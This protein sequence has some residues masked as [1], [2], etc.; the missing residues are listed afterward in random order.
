[1][2][3]RNVGGG[4]VNSLTALELLHGVNSNEWS[5]VWWRWTCRLAWPLFPHRPISV[6]WDAAALLGKLGPAFGPTSWSSAAVIRP[7][8]GK[9]QKSPFSEGVVLQI[10]KSCLMDRVIYYQWNAWTWHHHIF[11][12]D[13]ARWM[14]GGW[15]VWA[16]GKWLRGISDTITCVICT[17]PTCC[18]FFW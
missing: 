14:Y 5:A 3:R 15:P 8:F 10:K 2:T 7:E 9:N 12:W 1:M 13:K 17:P 16:A 11:F 18:E 6:S 4:A